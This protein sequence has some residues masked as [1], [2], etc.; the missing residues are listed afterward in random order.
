MPTL[1]VAVIAA[2]FTVPVKVG[3]ALIAKVLPVP[4]CEATAVALPTDVI[5]PVRLALVVTLP[6]VV[7]LLALPTSEPVT[8]VMLA[9]GPVSVPVNVGLALGSNSA[10]AAIRAACSALSAA[11][12]AA[13][14]A[15]SAADIV[16][17][18]SIAIQAAPS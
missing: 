12:R 14:S 18:L 8:V 17:E 13:V 10:S 9:A 11:M 7:A 5:G 1:P 4:V 16:D 15:A 6:A 3:L 2:A